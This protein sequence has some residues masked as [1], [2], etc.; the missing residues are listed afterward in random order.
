[1]NKSS[2]GRSVLKT[3]LFLF[4]LIVAFVLLKKSIFN[5]KPPALSKYAN[6]LSCQGNPFDLKVKFQSVV[7]LDKASTVPGWE[8]FYAAIF[9]QNMFSFTNVPDYNTTPGLKWTSLGSKEPN[10]KIL[11]VEDAKYPISVVIP[12]DLE[13]RGFPTVPTEYLKRLKARRKINKNDPAVKVTYEYENN[14]L[15][16]LDKDKLD[17]TGIKFVQPIDPYTAYFV[18]PASQQK[19]IASPVSKNK[20]VVNPCLNP[21]AINAAAVSPFHLWF[22]WRPFAEG[23]DVN[24]AAFNCKDYYQ[25]KVT[26]NTLNMQVTENDPKKTSKLAFNQFEKLE[27][28][29]SVSLFLGSQETIAFE[30]FNKEEAENLIK[31][32]MSGI[33]LITAKRELPYKKNKYDATFSTQLWFLRNITE[34]MDVKKSELDVGDYYSKVTLKGKLKLSHKD[35]VVK[36]FLNQTNPKFESSESF[37]KFFSDEFLNNDIVIYGGH[38]GNGTIFRKSLNEYQDKMRANED[39]NMHYQIFALFS[40]TAHFFYPPD[41]FPRIS[42]QDFRRDFILTGGGFNDGSANS[43]LILI[44]QV[45]SY[46]YNKQYAPFSALSKLAKADNFYILSNH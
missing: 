35:I 6:Y 36:V 46:L 9:Y 38:V 28:P 3:G 39:K 7:Y 5:P 19:L 30:K 15:V 41:S 26:I 44:G 1:M 14:L 37:A 42:N 2:N 32:Y 31:Y 13:I 25:D 16:C 11:K 27:R 34:R 22:F 10:M 23:H 8:I 24:K 18:V 21:Q 40:C 45:D 43:S 17:L 29:L 33:D 20:Q 12:A 4:C